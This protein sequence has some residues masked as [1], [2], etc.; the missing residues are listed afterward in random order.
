VERGKLREFCPS[1]PRV[2]RNLGRTDCERREIPIGNDLGGAERGFDLTVGILDRRLS[3]LV[4][5]IAPD[6]TVPRAANVIV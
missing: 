3:I 4:P 2:E 5:R 1:Y 6:S